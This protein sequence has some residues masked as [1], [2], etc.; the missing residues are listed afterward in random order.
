MDDAGEVTDV[1]PSQVMALQLLIDFLVFQ[2]QN[3][4]VENCKFVLAI[5]REQRAE[6]KFPTNLT[7]YVV[8]ALCS[9]NWDVFLVQSVANGLA[10]FPGIFIKFLD[11]PHTS[12]IKKSHYTSQET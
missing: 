3:T 1:L 12:L 8:R 11:E 4:Y 5:Y 6:W 7:I 9:N 2:L 10:D